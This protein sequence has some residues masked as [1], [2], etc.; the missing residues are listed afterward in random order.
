MKKIYMT[1]AIT[2]AMIDSEGFLANSPSGDLN[3]KDPI[4]DSGEIES[5]VNPNPVD[6]VAYWDD[7]EDES[8]NDGCSYD[9][10]TKSLWY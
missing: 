4:T 5:K 10:H 3:S 6:D 2:M 1:P 8:D 7:D 9:L